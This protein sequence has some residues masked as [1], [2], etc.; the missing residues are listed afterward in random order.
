MGHYFW[1]TQYACNACT[2]SLIFLE[3][4]RETERERDR[5][6]EK[7]DNYRAYGL[8]CVLRIKVRQSARTGNQDSTCTQTGL[9]HTGQTCWRPAPT[10]NLVVC[11]VVTLLRSFDTETEKKH[12]LYQGY[13]SQ[14]RFLDSPC[15]CLKYH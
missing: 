12:Y 1:D 15:L 13:W 11:T 7:K 3:R 8:E 10:S 2:K 6:R 4:E 9:Y 5:E 14:R